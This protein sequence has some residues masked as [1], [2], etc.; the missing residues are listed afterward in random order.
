MTIYICINCHSVGRSLD[1]HYSVYVNQ[2]THTIFGVCV[3]CN[4]K[5]TADEAATM[6]SLI[7]LAVLGRVH[8]TI[9]NDKVVCR[10]LN[11]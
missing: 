4:A 6:K 5:L 1:G 3:Q 2:P 8:M 11:S 10:K 9:E 7:D